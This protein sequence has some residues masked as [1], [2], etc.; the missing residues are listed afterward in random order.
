M[1]KQ[2]FLD[3]LQKALSGIPSQEVDEQLA[4]YGE[5]IDDLVEE[6][7]SQEEAVQRIGSVDDIAAQIKSDTPLKNIIKEEAKRSY[8]LPL[9]AIV[10][11]IIGAPVWGSILIGVV[12]S[13]FSLVVV[14][15]ST[16]IILWAVSF[17][18]GGC[19]IGG[20][21][22]GIIHLTLG[23]TIPAF[24]LLG[25]ALVCIGLTILMVM[26]SKLT[27]KGTLWCYRQIIL[28]IK[29]LIARRRNA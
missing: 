22:S 26:V 18:I 8:S 29:S 10:L 16:I 5:M 28:L 7:L 4:F 6:G 3:K 1:D 9:W 12:S 15:L 27:V 19:A 25:A 11:L 14:I 20:I 23:N 2:E 17:A 21:I 24:C 13:I